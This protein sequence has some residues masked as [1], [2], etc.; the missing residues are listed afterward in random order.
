MI[1]SYSK[2]LMSVFM[3]LIMLLS[4]SVV[5]AY[6]EGGSSIPAV[7][8]VED[9]LTPEST[10]ITVNVQNKPNLGILR[11]IVLDGAGKYDGNQLNSYPSLVFAALGDLEDGENTLTLEKAPAVGKQVI[12]V[13]RDA[14][15]GVVDY[16]S[17]P[18]TVTAAEDEQGISFVE[19]SL[20]T[21]ATSVTVNLKKG[22]DQGFIKI[23]QLDD[24]EVYDED[25]IFTYAEVATIFYSSL[26]TP[27]DKTATF[28]AGSLTAGNKVYAVLLEN[29]N[30]YVAGP[31]TVSAAAAA[32]EI[33]FTDESVTQLDDTVHVT[34]NGLP[35]RYVF[36]ILELSGA[37]SDSD[38]ISNTNDLY[39]GSDGSLQSGENT[40][41][42][43]RKPTAGKKIYAVVRDTTN[44]EDMKDYVSEPLFV[45][46]AIDE[47]LDG[48]SV[49]LSFDDVSGTT[50]QAEQVTKATVKYTL[51]QYVDSCRLTIVAY[52]PNSNFDTEGLAQ[53]IGSVTV[54]EKSGSREIELNT[55]DVT[56]KPG[57]NIRAYLY[58][59]VNP[60]GEG[61]YKTVVSNEFTIV[62][63]NGSG[64]IPYT[65]PSVN[66]VETE[67]ELKAGE[68][69]LHLTLT[70]DER[71]FKLAQ[72]SEN[73]LITLSVQ[74]Y[75]ADKEFDFEGNYMHAL[76]SNY[77]V[78]EAFANQ[79][80][81]L[82]EPLIEGYK[83]RAVVYWSQDKENW[84][85]KGNDYEYA[86]N[87]NSVIVA[88]ASGEEEDKPTAAIQP[89]SVL[90]GAESV[91]VNVT[92]TIP[93]GSQMIL[94][95]YPKGEEFQFG[96][97]GNG[98]F[99]CNISPVNETN[100]FDLSEKIL[101]SEN[102]LIA[103][104]LDSNF[105][106][107]A[108]SVPVAIIEATG[109]LSVAINQS[110]IG[111]GDRKVSVTVSGTVPDN[112]VLVVQQYP[113]DQEHDF[114]NNG[115]AVGN[116]SNITAGTYEV[117]VSGL[118]PQNK[119]IAVIL[120]GGSPQTK[121]N[122][123]S[124]TV[125]EPSI[126]ITETKITPGDTHLSGKID[127]EANYYDSVAYTVYSYEDTLDESTAK[128]ISSGTMTSVSA[129]G[130]KFSVKANSLVEGRKLIAKLTLTKGEQTTTCY[131]EV[132][133]VE[134]APN[135]AIPTVSIDAAAVR[136]SDKTIP[137]TVTYDRGY[138]DIT[139]G[140]YCNIA[141]YQYPS[142][143]SDDA[144][145]EN[146]LHEK[147]QIAQKV[148]TI[149]NTTDDEY[150]TTVDLP[151]TGTLEAGTR[152]IVKLRL[153]HAE[154]EEEEADYFS[155]SVPVIGDDEEIPVPKVLLFNLGEET[156]TG[157]K[158]RSIL[159]DL[160]I[161]VVTIE[162][163]EINEKVGYLAGLQG[164]Q[165]VNDPYTG[166]DYTTEFV[167]MSNLSETQL[168]RFLAEMRQAGIE[169]NHKAVITEYTKEWPFIE[170]LG[171]IAE[172]HDVFQAL[173]AL[174]EMI[175]KAEKLD[176][177]D[178]TDQQE[179]WKELQTALSK[180][181]GVISSE[182]PTLEQL[183]EAT[184]ELKAVYIALTGMQEMTGDAV[185]TISP[186]G[187][188]TYTMTANVKNGI[189]GL[190][191]IYQWSNG[192]D[193]QTVTGIPAEKLAGM[194]V[195]ITA[196]EAI[197]T[198][199]AKLAVPEAPKATAAGA[200]KAITLTWDTPAA[201]D[202]RPAPTQYVASVYLNGVLV[203]TESCG[204]NQN[205]MTISGL[206]AKTNYTVK[207]YAE[208]PV[209]R[210][211]IVTV[212]ATTL[213]GSSSSSSDSSSGNT[214][215]DTYRVSIS[216]DNDNG[217]VSV[218]TKNAKKGDTVTITVKPDR[219]Y[220][221]EDVIVTDQDGEKLKL[222]DKGENQYTF[223]MPASKVEV[224]VTFKLVEKSEDA[225]DDEVVVEPAAPVAFADVVENDWFA[226]AVQYVA[227]RA[228]MNGDDGYFRPYENLTR[229]M[230]AQ[231]LY[232]MEDSKDTYAVSFPDVSALDWY[233]D[234]VAWASAQS[235][236]VGYDSGLFGAKDT[237]TR[238]QLAA[239]FY[240]YAESRGYEMTG[241][242]D[243]IAFV[244]G[245]D[246]SAW[247]RPA[248]QWAVANNL[249]SGKAN[250]VLDPKG[251]ATRAE[252]ASILMRFCE[253]MAKS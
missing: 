163:N 79:E 201:Q 178:Y 106:V 110:S 146:E 49:Q 74:Q 184:N 104:I 211:D 212:S 197:G 63:A 25:K 47:I 244:D 88:A 81:D 134:A 142:Y 177:D 213:K 247:A 195:G 150:F 205:A 100:I 183:Q 42:L 8:I 252:V 32:T 138:L 103:V 170:L 97:G 54:S 11:V 18:V 36:K 113:K 1:R 233:A 253:T 77:K 117:S 107:I 149:S 111:V 118:S 9:T 125:K 40:I 68:Q 5:P 203:K 220:E 151:V 94:Y 69:K 15:S 132:R 60:A 239:I 119:L 12:A 174:N 109:E 92:G 85:P 52:P 140:Y 24:N 186:D 215:T 7:S 193:T 206:A 131:S 179:A 41:T 139:G 242:A 50:I 169:I 157:A 89:S 228:I 137:V 167:L 160:G 16:V 173:L 70:G 249:I 84:I 80:F 27:G 159:Q 13:L 176:E 172:E 75:P 145:E 210:S 218:D 245:S 153:P 108:T 141:A 96:Y 175:Q 38:F 39:V 164:Y 98:I 14:S 10:S 19:S 225:S 37:Y 59:S 204:G 33:S 196:A 240:R 26:G 156:S 2:R 86:V 219:G 181:K 124:I 83:V 152:L 232:N 114:Y 64:F 66:I 4:M 223:T 158:L 67:G 155:M 62:D 122:P 133:T 45:S 248:M 56:L 28:D 237:V 58:I 91:T 185:I 207:L 44:Y 168:D 224:D 190:N 194:T 209:G 229:G 87:D 241:A 29:G 17:D 217:T 116:Q 166:K 182:E 115:S 46:S 135:W 65:Y 227:E 226:G 23:I 130:F 162:M 30:Q 120:A 251:T 102:N 71:L 222:K 136:V 238:E 234:A 21:D 246:T 73:F 202:N 43:N 208:S 127:F 236:M 189:A 72:E 128:V 35:E 93:E 3:A 191:Y 171:E 154:W 221:V 55:S 147:P 143:Y 188:G 90:V 187:N 61:Y 199:S 123:I 144:F 230:M 112:A 101:Y 231:I 22:I 82:K 250:A 216:S 31:I 6:A 192:A 95:Q 165:T 126:A 214:S 51:S 180:A 53:P 105:E 76:V 200:K 99:V 161:Q 243:L 121:S 48:C 198:L 20:T 148:A 57:M 129:S 235:I 78:T 34:I